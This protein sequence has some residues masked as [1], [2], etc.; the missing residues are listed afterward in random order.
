MSRVLLV[1]RLLA[2][3]Q[4]GR[5]LLPRPA[6]PAGVADLQALETLGESA[7]CERGAQT[8]SDIGAA[9]RNREIVDLRHAVKVN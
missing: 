1:H 4:R 8:G 3:F 7:Q 9:G 6:L 5:D 2:D